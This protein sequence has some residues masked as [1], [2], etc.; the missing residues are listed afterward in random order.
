MATA[1]NAPNPA[2]T[3][4]TGKRKP[5]PSAWKKGQSGNPKGRP[6][7]GESWAATIKRIS[8]MTGEEASSYVVAVAKQL[9]PLKGVTLK[10][11][12][13]M[14]CFAALMF[15]PQAA[16]FNAIVD[17]AEG[18][19]PQ[20]FFDVSQLMSKARELGLTDDAIRSDPLL[21]AIFATAGIDG[22]GDEPNP[23]NSQSADEESSQ[24]SDPR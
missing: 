19:M 1:G 24:D 10:E 20:G 23:E 6:A 12:V 8:G 22:F 2:N 17:R 16:M 11:A 14:R 15:E 3:K 9:K 7:D 5:S 21:S 4:K 13:V 18:K